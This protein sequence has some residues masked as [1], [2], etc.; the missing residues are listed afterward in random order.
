MLSSITIPFTEQSNEVTKH[1]D[2]GTAADIIS[3]LHKVDQQ[4][5]SGI[6][7][8]EAQRM[9]GADNLVAL[10]SLA[11]VIAD[12]ISTNLRFMQQQRQ[13]QQQE[14]TES[15]TA[16]A[17]SRLRLP[18]GV[19]FA[20]CG[21]SGRVAFL[22]ARQFNK[23][24]SADAQQNGDA[25][26]SPTASMFRYIMAAGDDALVL[27][28]ELPEDDPFDGIS[29]LRQHEASFQHIVVVGITCG[30]SAPFVAGML[31]FAMEH[32][33]DG[34]P[35]SSAA[36][37]T[38]TYTAV[39]LGFN[40]PALARDAN[41][42]KWQNKDKT[43]RSVFLPLAQRWEAYCSQQQQQSGT[44]PRHDAGANA[45]PSCIAITPVVGAEAI[46]GSSRM[47]G[48]SATMIMICSVVTAAF[49]RSR[50]GD[51]ANSSLRAAAAA[52]AGEDVAAII[53][54][55]Q[56]I[57]LPAVYGIDSTVRALA[58]I[59]ECAART[60]QEK[61][62][63][64][65]YC[66]VCADGAAAAIGIMDASEMVDTYGCPEDEWRALAVGGWQALRSQE[67]ERSSKQPANQ[68]QEY[69]G[70]APPM[71]LL[72]VEALNGGAEKWLRRGDLLVLLDIEPRDQHSPTARQQQFVQRLLEAAPRVG[73][74][75]CRVTVQ[76][77]NSNNNNNNNNNTVSTS[78]ATVIGQQHCVISIRS[79][80]AMLQSSASSTVGNKNTITVS[81][82][83]EFAL[84]LATNAISTSA[85]ILRGAVYQ[86]RMIN[87]TLS[88]N[89]LFFRTLSMVAM[90]AGCSNAAARVALLRAIYDEDDVNAVATLDS[91]K[92]VAEHVIAA[93]PVQNVLPIA[94]L[95]ASGAAATTSD[96]RVLLAA[97]GTLRSAMK[98]VVENAATAMAGAAASDSMILD[99]GRFYLRSARWPDDWPAT[100]YVCLKTGD[101]G[102]DGEPFYRDDPDALGRVYVAP[103]LQFETRFAIVICDKEANNNRVAGYALGALDTCDF[104]LEQYDKKSR[105]AMCKE[106][107]DP[108]ATNKPESEWTRAEQMHHLYHHP[109]FQVQMDSVDLEKYPS[110]LHIDLL[111]EARGGGNG[112]AMIEELLRQLKAAG[113]VGVHL[114]MAA[115]NDKALGFYKHAFGFVE[116][117]QVGDNLYLGK[118]L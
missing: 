115:S 20:G 104:F 110:H 31:D 91:Q 25:L 69:G 51:D 39:L 4:L 52:A 60:I 57:S 103:Y 54:S 62:N 80:E 85:Q 64:V 108:A 24:F 70:H 65:V 105:P 11:D 42:E 48:G 73:F 82:D 74:Q 30:L 112:R 36:A 7:G 32:G 34:Q 35:S 97:S 40:P 8:F 72:S 41:I 14:K 44:A 5:F 77:G 118:T 86:N 100:S 94:T 15:A 50:R 38:T 1:I 27:S 88:N 29:S 79:S 102:A 95:L 101:R 2:Q 28:I 96:A 26:P 12:A 19:V 75:V 83:A 10:G 18:V 89:K 16:S 76:C 55:F 87:V 59:A 3:T 37:A 63:R 6:S 107:Q 66:G 33:R 45:F 13:Q 113:S 99:R 17:P 22:C 98:R 111:E 71:D 67:G 21:T 106:W 9:L 56:E 78:S 116:I 46:T 43:C 53:K 81:F 93:T 92:S 68:G 114:C 47:K 49:H 109:D 117:K 23:I 90:F 61:K 58:A 84:K